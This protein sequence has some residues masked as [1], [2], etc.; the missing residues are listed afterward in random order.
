MSD[1]LAINDWGWVSVLLDHFLANA[2]AEVEEEL[3]IYQELRQQAFNEGKDGQVARY[4]KHLQRVRQRDLLGFLASRNILPKYGFPVDVVEL[5]MTADHQAVFD[6]D[7]S[8]DLKIAIGEYAPGAE[9]VAGGWLWK[10]TAIRRVPG[11]EC[12]EK[13]YAVCAECGRFVSWIK[14][15]DAPERCPSCDSELRQSRRR[16]SLIV[17]E[18]GFVCSERPTRVPDR[19]P[20]RQWTSRVYF[21]DYRSDVDKMAQFS[22]VGDSS[23]VRL[24]YRYSRQGEF[25]VIN[26]GPRGTGFRICQACGLALPTNSNR[27]HISPFGKPCRGSSSFTHL[28]HWFQTDLIEIRLENLPKV[29]DLTNLW[30]SL[31]Y[32]LVRGASIALDIPESEIGACLYPHG[33]L[34]VPPAIVLYDDIPG[35]GGHAKRIGARLHDVWEAALRLLEACTCDPDTACYGC[36]KSYANQYCHDHLQ[37]GPAAVALAEVERNVFSP[38]AGQ[39]MPIRYCNVGSWLANRMEVADEI[40]A[41]VDRIESP[42]PAAGRPGIDWATDVFTKAAAGG[43]RV[44]LRVLAGAQVCARAISTLRGTPGI[45]LE[46]GLV[47]ATPPQWPIALTFRDGIP[48]EVIGWDTVEDFRREGFSPETGAAGLKLLNDSKQVAFEIESMRKLM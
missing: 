7:L 12:P 5:H 34:T 36:I 35:G 17:P 27:E 32:G 8:R 4:G 31:M 6:L 46:E 45:D 13:S 19:K 20:K 10:P 22:L 14:G 30:P 42:D 9:V 44:H 18:F 26:R 48:P 39:T 23:A 24:G 25:V 16:G 37:R 11:R 1:A 29:R 3:R 43:T 21:A 47:L 38:A 28:G 41:I 2:R 15:V 40:L 33:D